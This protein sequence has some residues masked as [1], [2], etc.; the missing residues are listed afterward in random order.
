[1][2]IAARIVLLRSRA[3]AS[4]SPA[5]LICAYAYFFKK[6]ISLAINNFNSRRMKNT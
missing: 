2:I 5:F 4:K 3:L 1:M 6:K